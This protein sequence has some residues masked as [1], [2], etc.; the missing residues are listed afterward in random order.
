MNVSATILTID[1]NCL[2]LVFICGAGTLVFVTLF[3]AGAEINVLLWR[4]SVLSVIKLMISSLFT[5]QKRKVLKPLPKLF[6]DQCLTTRNVTDTDLTQ[7]HHG[8]MKMLSAHLLF[9]S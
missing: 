1:L 5:M 4:M 9:T 3:A 7:Q 6:Y 8:A 2:N